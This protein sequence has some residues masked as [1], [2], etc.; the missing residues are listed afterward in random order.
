MLTNKRC[1]CNDVAFSKVFFWPTC[2]VFKKSTICAP[3]DYQPSD[4]LAQKPIVPAA[5]ALAR[6]HEQAIATS[7]YSRFV[8]IGLLSAYACNSKAAFGIVAAEIVH[9]D[10]DNQIFV[11]L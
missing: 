7:P 4:A 1:K 3:K 8:L 10:F 5:R 6:L 11:I 9:V 2:A